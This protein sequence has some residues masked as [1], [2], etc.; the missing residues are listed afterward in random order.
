[1]IEICRKSPN[2]ARQR[3]V[4]SKYEHGQAQWEEGPSSAIL[5]RVDQGQGCHHRRRVATE[6]DQ[7]KKFE[8]WPMVE[9]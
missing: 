1:M 7:A 3:P 4:P 9:E 8:R 6:D 5:G 2:E